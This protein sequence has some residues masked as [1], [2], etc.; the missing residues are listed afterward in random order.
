MRWEVI[1]PNSNEELLD[2]VFFAL[3][4][5]IDCLQETGHMLITFLV[6]SSGRGGP[7]YASFR[8]PMRKV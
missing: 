5:G 6:T 4:Y 1:M 3:D 8:Q 7:S 2:L